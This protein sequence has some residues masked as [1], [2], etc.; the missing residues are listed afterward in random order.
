VLIRTKVGAR[1]RQERTTQ[2][3]SSLTWSC[4]DNQPR[5]GSKL[6][7]LASLA[8]TLQDRRVRGRKEEEHERW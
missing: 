3:L 8:L 6:D 4:S 2:T 7:K 5:D 1:G